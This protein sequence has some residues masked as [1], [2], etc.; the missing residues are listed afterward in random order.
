VLHCIALHLCCVVLYCFVLCCVV[1][2]CVVLCCVVFCCTSDLLTTDD[3]PG[4]FLGVVRRKR[5]SSFY[6]GNI[7]QNSTKSDIVNYIESKGDTVLRC[8][9]LHCIVYSSV[10]A[11]S[12]F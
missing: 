3:S 6:I 7:D 1:L 10:I 5:I 11:E 9:A 4:V 12:H 8:I 2:C